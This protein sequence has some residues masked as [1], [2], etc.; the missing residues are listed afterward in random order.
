[1][2]T[3][4]PQRIETISTRTEVPFTSAS[5]KSFTISRDP[6]GNIVVQN[7]K[8]ITLNEGV[9]KSMLNRNPQTKRA[10]EEALGKLK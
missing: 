2:R 9:V 7:S 1:M 10:Y 8:G 5:G 4:R 6:A 3:T